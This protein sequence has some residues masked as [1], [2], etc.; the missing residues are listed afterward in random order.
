[1]DIFS[2][3]RGSGRHI[4]QSCGFMDQ[5]FHDRLTHTPGVRYVQVTTTIGENLVTDS[6]DKKEKEGTGHRK[7]R[8]D[9]NTPKGAHPHKF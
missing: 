6:M 7:P 2:R 3:A 4:S 9:G 8:G 5:N 1:V